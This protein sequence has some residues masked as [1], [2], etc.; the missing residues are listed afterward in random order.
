MKRARQY[1][2]GAVAAAMM[3]ATGTLAAQEAAAEPGTGVWRNYDFVRGD[4]IWVATDFSGERVGRFPASQLEFVSGSMEIV[5][6]GGVKLLEAKSASVLRVKLPA[7]LPEQFTIEFTLEIGAGHFM[8]TVFTAPH[9]GG[10]ARAAGD[11]LNLFSRPGIFREGKEV[12]GAADRALINKLV[13]V[14]LQVDGEYAILYV[15]ANRVSAVP[16]AKFTRGSAI[17]IRMNGQAGRETYISDIVVAVG[18]DP[19]YDRLMSS[20]EVTSYGILFDVDSDKLRP[21]STPTLEAL[22][23]MLADH[24]ELK[25]GIEGHTDASGD[26]AHN[27]ALSQRRAAAVV[28]YLTANGIGGARLQAV[29]KGET[30]PVGDNATAV[31]RQQN[32]RV[33]IRKM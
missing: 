8:T 27:L 20:G 17:E 32:R 2:T 4:S 28:A 10:P 30:V 19:L 9:E 1:V 26:D 18:L 31:G 16:N 3:L 7:E 24:A 29:G 12:A 33:V 21:E 15:G 23:K 13:P 22:R 25:I 5:E 6:R 14:K 11:Y